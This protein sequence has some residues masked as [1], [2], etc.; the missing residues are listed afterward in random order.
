MSGKSHSSGP[1]PWLV[2]GSPSEF[3][4]RQGTFLQTS[5]GNQLLEDEANISNPHA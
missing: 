3:V 5:K 2:V 1:Y 4:W